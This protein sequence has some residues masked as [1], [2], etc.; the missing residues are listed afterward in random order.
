MKFSFRLFQKNNDEHTVNFMKQL[1]S[2]YQNENS[3]LY[4]TGTRYHRNKN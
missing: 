4:K 2:N 1:K 3:C